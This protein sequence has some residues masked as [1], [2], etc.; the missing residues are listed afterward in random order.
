MLER[1]IQA[2]SLKHIALHPRLK[3]LRVPD[4]V[5]LVLRLAAEGKPV[6]KGL[7]I[8]ARAAM[9][10]WPDELIFKG[11]G[12]FAG[13]L[14]RENKRDGKGAK[15]SPSQKDFFADL[16]ERGIPGYVCYGLDETLELTEKFSA[17][18]L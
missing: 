15:L 18:H 12:P 8:R 16:A 13:A 5:Y 6:S 7:G 9:A 1:D 14:I 2:M 11:M 3:V 10:A 4:E 17:W